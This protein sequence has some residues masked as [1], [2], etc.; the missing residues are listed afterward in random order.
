MIAKPNQRISN[1]VAE[2]VRKLREAGVLKTPDII[3]G[4]LKNDRKKFVPPEF[5]E[6]AYV[7]SPLPIGEGQTIS[8][9]YTVAFMM[10]LLEPRPGQKVLDIGFGSGWTT[11]ILASIV[12][13]AGKVYALEVIPEVYEFGKANLRKCVYQNIELFNK[14]GWDG[15]AELAPF[16][17][18]I[19]GAAAPEIP[20]ALKKQLAVGGRMVIPVGAQFNC[21]IRLLERVSAE[22]YKERDYPGFAFVPFVE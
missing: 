10:E 3:D 6:D 21:A 4:F 11:A 20:L 2:L 15:L 17:R 1:G 14:S 7:D 19:A 12:G 9:P 18:I 8:Q 13:R 22:N 16:D 5:L